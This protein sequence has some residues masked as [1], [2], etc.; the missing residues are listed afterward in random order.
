MLDLK[1]EVTSLTISLS[2]VIFLIAVLWYF[3]AVFL[4]LPFLFS[5]QC[6]PKEVKDASGITEVKGK[7]VFYVENGKVYVEKA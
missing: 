3:Q 6:K 7:I 2:V 4:G 1:E 5:I